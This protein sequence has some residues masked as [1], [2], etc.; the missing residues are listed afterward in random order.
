[1][2]NNENTI[3]SITHYLFYLLSEKQTNLSM[4]RAL[5]QTLVLKPQT[6]IVTQP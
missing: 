5:L 4:V 2:W 3:I 1:M 6:K